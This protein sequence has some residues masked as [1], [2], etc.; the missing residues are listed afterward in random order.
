MAGSVV[1]KK[2]ILDKVVS[3]LRTRIREID[4]L[5]ESHDFSIAEQKTR[6]LEHSLKA[7]AQKAN[8]LADLS[9]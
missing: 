7:A 4:S 1:D 6:T 8:M 5:I 9:E 3:D 2:A